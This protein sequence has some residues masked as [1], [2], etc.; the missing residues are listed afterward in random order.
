MKR[1]RLLSL[2][3]AVVIGYGM[4]FS[5]PAVAGV[6]KCEIDGSVQYSDQPCPESSH[7]AKMKLKKSDRDPSEDSIHGTI[8]G[9]LDATTSWKCETVKEAFEFLPSA[10]SVGHLLYDFYRSSPTKLESFSKVTVSDLRLRARYKIQK[11]RPYRPYCS[12]VGSRSLKKPKASIYVGI[13]AKE[14]IPPTD[15]LPHINTL[16]NTLRQN[17][18]HLKQKGDHLYRY[19]WEFY[20]SRCQAELVARHNSAEQLKGTGLSIHCG[21]RQMDN[22]Q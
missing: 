5:V 13:N 6:F 4:V 18:Y 12:I 16:L 10:L 22:Q 2:S 3:S 11:N 14:N 9:G 7:S 19:D 8:E 21:S 17:G 15:Q 1:P 20:E